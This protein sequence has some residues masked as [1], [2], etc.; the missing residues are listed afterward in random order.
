MA[1]SPK[2][3]DSLSN[4]DRQLLIDVSAIAQ[5]DAGTGI[6]RVVRNLY[7]ALLA[8]PPEGYRI[9]PVAATRK[10]F[11]AYLPTGFLQQPARSASAPIQ[12]CAGD[13][14][15]GLDLSAHIVPHHMPALFRW[16]QQG[17]R[18]SFV[19]YDLLPVLEPAWFNPKATRQEVIAYFG[20]PSER[21]TAIHLGVSPMFAPRTS[22]ELTPALRRYGLNPGAYTLCVSSSAR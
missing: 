15:L 18:M 19:I 17:V 5:A 10:Q 22:T 12:V 3:S 1:N 6:Q 7:Q 20:W 11:Y 2:R 16:K 9:C 14:F 13:I 4:T 8:A 21:V